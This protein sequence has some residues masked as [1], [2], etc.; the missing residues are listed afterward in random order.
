MMKISIRENNSL[1]PMSLLIAPS[2]KDCKFR[3][4][5]NWPAWTLHY[6]MFIVLVLSEKACSIVN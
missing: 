6:F 5:Y 3:L 4:S 1:F 2:N